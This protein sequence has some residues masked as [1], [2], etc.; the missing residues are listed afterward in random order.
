MVKLWFKRLSDLSKL[1]ILLKKG[2]AGLGL[3]LCTSPLD[4]VFFKEKVQC[5]AK[6]RFDLDCTW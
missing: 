6:V 1:F 4:D 5:E 3:Q 2:K